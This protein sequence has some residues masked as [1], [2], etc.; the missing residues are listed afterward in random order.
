MNYDKKI[1]WDKVADAGNAMVKQF[2]K[3]HNED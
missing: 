2:E 3:M 1:K